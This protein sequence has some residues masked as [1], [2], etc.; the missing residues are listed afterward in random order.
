[1]NSYKFHGM[2]GHLVRQAIVT[3]LN[4]PFSGIYKTIKDIN[5]NGIITLSDGR[6][7][8]LELTQIIDN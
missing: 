7:F 1:M 2:T 3:S 4:V 5:T 6:K 8:K